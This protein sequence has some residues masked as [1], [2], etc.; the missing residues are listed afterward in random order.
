MNSMSISSTPQVFSDCMGLASRCQRSQA[1]EKKPEVKFLGQTKNQSAIKISLEIM[2]INKFCYFFHL[3][4]MIQFSLTI[5]FCYK[6]KEFLSI[7]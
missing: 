4:N 2:Y 3:R 7:P 1:W 5:F 6:N